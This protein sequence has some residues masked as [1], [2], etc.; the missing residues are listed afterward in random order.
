MSGRRRA[1]N[2]ISDEKDWR[3]LRSPEEKKKKRKAVR[4]LFSGRLCLGAR[5]LG[6]REQQLERPEYVYLSLV[7]KEEMDLLM[8]RF[9]SSHHRR[10][11]FPLLAPA[12]AAVSVG[13]LS[14]DSTLASF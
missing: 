6:I 11:S 8:E 9:G 2:R 10:P 1:T 7:W 5:E 14:L 3:K 13:N 4:L 12:A